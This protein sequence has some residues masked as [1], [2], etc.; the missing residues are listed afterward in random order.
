M[1]GSIKNRFNVFY[2]ELCTVAMGNI[3][4]LPASNFFQLKLQIKEKMSIL[5]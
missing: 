1:S 5:Q 3:I 2:A 4:Q